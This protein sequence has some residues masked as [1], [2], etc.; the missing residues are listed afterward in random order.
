MVD[1]AYLSVLSMIPGAEVDRGRAERP[2]VQFRRRSLDLSI[3]DG[4]VLLAQPIRLRI[5][6]LAL[7]RK[8]ALLARCGKND[9]LDFQCKTLYDSRCPFDLLYRVGAFSEVLML[10]DEVVSCVTHQ[11]LIR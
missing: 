5:E 11:Q 9:A 7:F 6:S 10:V 3:E 8:G 4:L 2:Q 1:V